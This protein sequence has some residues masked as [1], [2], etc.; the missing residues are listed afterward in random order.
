M[1]AIHPSALTH[2]GK[3]ARDYDK[4]ATHAKSSFDDATAAVAGAHIAGFTSAAAMADASLT[5]DGHFDKQ[6]LVLEGI[7]GS[8]I[9][10]AGTYARH[11]HIG[12]DLFA[13]VA[14]PGGPR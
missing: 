11:D 6:Q 8:L 1:V 4:V 12:S 7:G 14:M 13:P 10:T 5:W 9:S 2:V 3:V